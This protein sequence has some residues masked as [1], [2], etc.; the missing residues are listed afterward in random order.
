MTKLITLIGISILLHACAITKTGL[1]E[2]LVDRYWRAVEIAG[3][4]VAVINNRAEPHF[5]LDSHQHTHGSDGCNRFNGEYAS[6][7]GLSFGRL[8]STRMACVAAVDAMSR[9]FTSALSKTANYR[10]SGRQMVLFD[11]EGRVLMRLE[12]TFLK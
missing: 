7:Q 8:A 3:N 6:A 2:P 4:P 12:A 5:V 11:T 9:D 10:I 1:D